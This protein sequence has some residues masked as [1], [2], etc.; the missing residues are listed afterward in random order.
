M[1]IVLFSNTA[2]YLYNF[3]LPLAKALRQRGDE[4]IFLS[5]PSEEGD[6]DQRLL[7]A[8]FRWMPFEFSRKGMN[9]LQDGMSI[10]RLARLYLGLQPDLVHQFTIKPVLY[11]SIAARMARI[12]H[13]VNSI[14][15]LGY[16]FADSSLKVKIVR[17]LVK[18]LYKFGTRGAL[19]I[20]QNP[21][22]QELFVSKGWTSPRRSVLIRGSGAD[23]AR[24]QPSSIPT[25]VPVVVMA[26]RLIYD[27][28]V[29]DFIEAAALLKQRGVQARFQ[30]VGT[31][32]LDNPNS[33]RPDEIQ[34][35]EQAGLVEYLGWQED[36]API[37]QSATIICQPSAYRE[38]V[39]K[40]LLE[41]AAS[42]R[43]L[44]ATDIPGCR[45]IVRQGENGFLVPV[46]DAPALANALQALI[47]SPELCAQMGLKGREI[48]EH[49]FSQDINISQTIEVYRALTAA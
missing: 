12:P 27:K 8:G 14:T 1:K 41:A 35:W 37:Y 20:F 10:F 17:Q 3:R 36:M 9:P 15:G 21:E 49:E 19:M 46:H 45:E 39:P 32:D 6:Y 43:P 13:V 33:V 5:P 34:A 26:A 47:E 38:G 23:T 4:V 18:L 31:P 22:D 16:I 25:G 24:F 44:V 40:T 11:G 29:T 48:V 7:N 28:G 2:W 42:A 30:L